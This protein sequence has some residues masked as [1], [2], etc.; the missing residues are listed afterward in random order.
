[1]L[2][3]SLPALAVML[4]KRGQQNRKFRLKFVQHVIRFLPVNKKLLTPQDG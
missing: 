1:M 3:V 2:T 4:L